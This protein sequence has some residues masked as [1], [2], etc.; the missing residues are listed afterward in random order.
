MS[1]RRWLIS[2]LAG[3]A[4]ALLIA[5]AL[6]HV[7]TD[8]LWYASLGAAD[9]WRAKYASLFWLRFMCGAVA[10]LFVFANLY[11]VR[12][13]VVSLVLPRRIGNLDIGEEVPRRRLTWTAALLSVAA[14]AACGAVGTLA[15]AATPSPRR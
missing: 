3:V 15:G 8:Y 2:G 5:R 10:T 9:V 4:V 11:A 14:G 6:A 1:G 13:S 7:Y 12:Q